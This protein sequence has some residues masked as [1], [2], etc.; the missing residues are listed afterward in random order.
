MYMAFGVK[1]VVE[2]DAP[3]HGDVVVGW[4]N[5]QTGKGGLDDYFLS[6]AHTCSD[7]AESCPDT[8][9]PGGK[10]N[11]VML[12]SVSRDNYTMLTFKRYDIKLNFMETI[13]IC[14]RPLTAEDV[15]DTTIQIN[16]PQ[17]IFWSVGYKKAEMRMK[18]KPMKNKGE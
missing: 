7:G 15:Y 12:N 11:V 17:E 1:D 6:G 18:H 10:K 16:Q 14:S 3:A 9:K 13:K 8:T 5:T 2:P 4:I